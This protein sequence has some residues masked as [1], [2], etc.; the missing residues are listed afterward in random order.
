[1]CKKRGGGGDLWKNPNCRVQSFEKL[2]LHTQTLK[3]APGLKK[4]SGQ[5]VMTVGGDA[6]RGGGKRGH[7]L[8]CP[9]HSHTQTQRHALF[10]GPNGHSGLLAGGSASPGLQSL[11]GRQEIL[12]SPDVS[13]GFDL[14]SG[15]PRVGRDAFDAFGCFHAPSGAER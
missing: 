7:L 11:L 14:K 12:K 9:S 2:L 4:T 13:I 15:V 5:S 3:H 1:M 6:E 10:P 8:Q